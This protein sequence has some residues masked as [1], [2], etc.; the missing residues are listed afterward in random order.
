MNYGENIANPS[1]T[2]GLYIHIP[3]CLTKCNYC[4]FNTYAGIENQFKNITRSISNEIIFWGNKLGSPKLKTIFLGG[5]TP[6]YLPEKYKQEIFNAIYLKFNTSECEEITIECNPDDISLE[7]INSW[8]NLGINRLSLGVQAFN[9]KILKNIG[10]RHNS[11]Q[12][13]SSIKIIQEKFKNFNLDLMFG[14]PN[15]NLDDWEKSLNIAINS[16]AT[17]LSLY[18]LQLEKGT[19]LNSDVEKGIRKIPDDDTTAKMYDLACK[20]LKKTRFKQYEISNWAIDKNICK[21]NLIYWKNKEFIGCGPGASSYINGFRFKNIKSPKIYSDIFNENPQNIKIQHPKIKEGAVIEIEKQTK[22]IKALETMM[23]G[24]RLNEGVSYTFFTKTVG[25]SMYQ[26]YDKEL[27]KLNAL[28]LI[29]EKNRKIKLTHKGKL[30]ANE[31]V[32]N[33]II[34]EKFK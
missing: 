27:T 7:K 31:V 19:P 5:G 4:D 32:S 10:R 14:L 6:S 26:L 16:N 25:E 3:F 30:L 13:E 21:H 8:K 12:A 9:D 20:T 11:F 1:T 34:E 23:L 2:L 15:Q 33:F 22:E 24:L 28:G 18:G 29:I 17:H